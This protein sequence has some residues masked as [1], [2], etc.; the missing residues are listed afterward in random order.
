MDDIQKS[1]ANTHHEWLLFALWAILVLIIDCNANNFPFYRLL[2]ENF[3]VANYR[4]TKEFTKG[5][6]DDWIVTYVDQINISDEM[7]AMTKEIEKMMKRF[8]DKDN[9]KKK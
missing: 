3:V 2:D 8:S 5:V 1:T 6:S 7:K 9:E 4:F